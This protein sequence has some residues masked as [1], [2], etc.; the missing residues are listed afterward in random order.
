[1]TGNAA[2]VGSSDQAR[3]SAYASWGSN[4]D[5]RS[6]DS[7]GVD[8]TT[9]DALALSE[10][11]EDHLLDRDAQ[12]ASPQT[13]NPEPDPDASAALAGISGALGREQAVQG[14]LDRAY[15]AGYQ[16][17]QEA[18]QGPM[19]RGTPL[20][21]ENEPLGYRHSTEGRYHA[22]GQHTVYGSPTQGGAVAEL[23][24]YAD[25][26]PRSYTEIDVDIRPN[27]HT[28]TGGVADIRSGLAAQNL[29]ESALTQ[30]SHS[31]VSRGWHSIVGEQPYSAPQQVAKGAIDAG[32]AAIHA[33]SAVADSQ[34]N[35]LP[36]N[37][38]PASLTPVQRQTMLP[39][40]SLGPV[41]SAQSASPM[42]AY[43]SEVAPGSIDMP[44]GSADRATSLRYGAI[45]GALD[46][47]VH[48][49]V[50]IAR[51]N[52]VNG[53]QIAADVGTG[54]VIGAGA[55]RAVDALAPRL[56][57]VRAGGVVGG[58]IQASVSGYTNHQAYQQGLI[59][60]ER[61]IAN[62]VVDTGTAV[63][64]GAGGAL[65]GAAIG[66][67]VPVAGTAVGAVA[68]FAVG[69]GAYYAIEAVDAATGFTDTLKDGLSDG[70]E[71]VSNWVRSWW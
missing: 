41:R 45:G 14:V 29:P 36:A 32:A 34:I 33:P 11:T 48:A 2:G 44:A 23:S 56:G 13:V 1:M 68:G 50:N 17:P 53:Q 69:V 5:E 64:A 60:G 18:Y 21:F 20:Q 19:H 58:A 46:S 3:D 12:P 54:A 8:P 22:S 51:G 39:D 47:V 63:A 40:G 9:G 26:A 71:S 37:A 30:A 67:V 24:V 62:T 35:V 42:P 27:P 55:T 59:S 57:F 7:G 61:A 25:S 28:G 65:A 49:G 6:E 15:A 31:P 38:D 66:S 4:G 52:D 70:L 10:T 43:G 16:A